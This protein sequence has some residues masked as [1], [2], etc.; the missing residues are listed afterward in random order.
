MTFKPRKLEYT[1]DSR[2]NNSLAL[3]NE[4]SQSNELLQ[5]YELKANL[6]PDFPILI[7]IIGGTGAGKSLLFN[8]LTG[9]KFSEVGVKR[10]CTKGAVICCPAASVHILKNLGTVWAIDETTRIVTSDQENLRNIILVDTPD[11]DSVEK[12]NLIISNRFFVLSDV[13]LFVASEEKYADLLGRNVLRRSLNWGKEI[14]VILNKALTE[15]AFQDFSQS[16]KKEL[17]SSN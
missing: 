5:A 1:L 12:D 2:L 13:I 10:P 15:T 8:S 6:H 7:C 4:I 11:F 17:G 14:G 3:L 9:S 16:L